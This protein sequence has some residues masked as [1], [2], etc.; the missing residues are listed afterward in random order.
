[1]SDSFD[2]VDVELEACLSAK[3]YNLD[4]NLFGFVVDFF[5]G[6][7]LINESTLYYSDV[8]AYAVFSINF[9]DINDECFDLLLCVGIRL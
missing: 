9:S 3:H 8:V 6:T 1:M 7:C 2:V 4:F 5:N